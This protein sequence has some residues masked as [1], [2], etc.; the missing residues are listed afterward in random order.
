MAENNRIPDLNWTAPQFAAFIEGFRASYEGRGLPLDDEAKRLRDEI[1][2]RVEAMLA[3]EQ[4]NP[5]EDYFRTLREKEGVLRTA[6]GLHYR[7]TEAGFGVAA[8]ADDTVVL[9]FSARLPDGQTVPALSRTRVRAAVKDLLPGLAEGV[10]LLRVGGKALMYLSPSLA[11][12]E[13]NW[14]ADVP[15]GTPLAFFVE[16]HEIVGAPK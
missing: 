6:S 14:P 4:P 5:V 15:R 1:S 2:Q 9:S 16:L 11:F 13:Q 12:T 7:I 10:Q 3:R 8:A